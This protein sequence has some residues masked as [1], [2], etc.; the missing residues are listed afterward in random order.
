MEQTLTT[1]WPIITFLSSAFVIA[2]VWFIRLESKVIACEKEIVKI[3]N[4]LD[5]LRL[6]HELKIDGV[7]SSTEMKIDSLT[8]LLNEVRIILARIEGGLHKDKEQKQQ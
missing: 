3:E 4:S 5:D 7:K 8:S 6:K 1:F 2:L